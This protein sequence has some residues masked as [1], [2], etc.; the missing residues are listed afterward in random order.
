MRKFM[1]AD[2]T[3]GFLIIVGATSFFAVIQL[4]AENPRLRERAWWSVQ[5]ARFSNC[6]S[7]AD[8]T[9]PLACWERQAAADIANAK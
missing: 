1:S 3:R 4:F 2:A 9:A 5:F 6:V 7:P 8:L